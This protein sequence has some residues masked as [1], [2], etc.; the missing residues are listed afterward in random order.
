M[1]ERILILAP[2]SDD[3]VLGCGGLAARKV[4]DGCFVHIALVWAGDQKFYHCDRTIGGG[5]RVEEFL[6]AADVLG[7][8]ETSVLYEGKENSPDK[9]P[10]S[11]MVTRFDGMLVDME[12]TD[13]YIPYPSSHQDHRIVYEAGFAAARPSP[14]SIKQV[15]CY[16]Y[17]VMIWSPYPVEFSGNKYVDI[18]EYIDLKIKALLCHH[19]Q[20]A[21]RGE[22]H[23]ITPDTVRV[24]AA[25]RGREAGLLYAE[26]FKV[27]REVE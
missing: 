6:N 25:M 24:F 3:D 9:I 1:N 27:L 22:G 23:L 18:S 2:H 26:R 15:F 7:V 21:G 17:P 20:I 16:E 12:I 14:G 11:D 13:L 4:R 19:S 10:V 8:T 5:E